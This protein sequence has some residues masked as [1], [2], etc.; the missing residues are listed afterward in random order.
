LD[1][2]VKQPCRDIREELQ[3]K[4]ILINDSRRAFMDLLDV[5]DS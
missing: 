2:I 1:Y 5:T 4:M 3:A